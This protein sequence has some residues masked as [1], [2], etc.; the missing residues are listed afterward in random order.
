LVGCDIHNADRIIPEFQHLQVGESI[1]VPH[2][3]KYKV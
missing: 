3:D 2:I 1:K